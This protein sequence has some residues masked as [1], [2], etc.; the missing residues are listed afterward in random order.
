[1]GYSMEDRTFILLSVPNDFID[2]FSGFIKN[3][4]TL[5]KNSKDHIVKIENVYV[6]KKPKFAAVP[7][8][9]G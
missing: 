2:K 3:I 8:E 9:G 7:I 5:N 6:K 4:N 1:M